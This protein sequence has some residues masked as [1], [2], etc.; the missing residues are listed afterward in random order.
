M[1][2]SDTAVMRVAALDA[3]LR[4]R[5]HTCTSAPEVLELFVDK[6]R[7]AEVAR[8]ADV[9]IP[10]TLA[11]E[12][13]QLPDRG[14]F[15]G[16]SRY[17]LKPR[18]SVAF[19]TDYGIKAMWVSTW[20]ELCRRLER[21]RARGHRMILQEYVPGPPSNHYFIDGFVDAGG[22]VAAK[23][24]RRRIRMFPVDFGNSTYMTTV[25]C[26]AVPE[27]CDVIDRLVAHTGYRG[28]FSAELK[29][30]ERD[31]RFRVVEV[32]VRPWLYVDFAARCG[33]DVCSMAY[34]DALGE[35]VAA[36]E[37]YEIG[38]SAVS[39]QLDWLAGRELRRQGSITAPALLR[40]WWGAD[41]PVFDW[42]DPM[43]SV[44]DGWWSGKRFLGRRC[45]RLLGGAPAT[46]T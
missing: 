20:D 26:S 10:F 21:V 14:L 44:H 16:S 3:R 45:R 25:E 12:G 24:A 9:R 29:R 39:P 23:L 41:Q 33:V 17:F 1:A 19:V 11:I 28:V 32:N 4:E 38:R 6:L 40:S 43:P 8:A 15:E 42:R 22:N 18:D 13:E 35:P 30:D 46:A 31:G 2:C 34:R 36:V 7:F 37:R 5:F 27:A